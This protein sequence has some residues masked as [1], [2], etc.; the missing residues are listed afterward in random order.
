[1]AQ[2]SVGAYMDFLDAT[3]S[4]YRAGAMASEQTAAGVLGAVTGATARAMDAAAEGAQGP[5][6]RPLPD[7]RLRR[8][9]RGGDLREN[10]R[11]HR[12]ADPATQ[13]L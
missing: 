3:F 5:R 8:D 2:E 6:R 12:R 1:M 13:G 10:R 9:E 4:Q 7:S 11:S